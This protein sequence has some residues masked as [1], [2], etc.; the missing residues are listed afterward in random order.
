MTGNGGVQD[1]KEIVVESGRKQHG[2]DRGSDDVEEDALFW[3][4]TGLILPPQI[5]RAI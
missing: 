1:L 2:P 5:A 4:G 3:M